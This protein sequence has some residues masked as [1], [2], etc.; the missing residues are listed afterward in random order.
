MTWLKSRNACWSPDMTSLWYMGLFG[1][2]T[3]A[4]ERKRKKTPKNKKKKQEKKTT[5]IYVRLKV[6]QG[7]GRIYQRFQKF[8]VKLQ[9]NLELI[10]K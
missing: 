1:F 3:E 4:R 8:P 9:V 6:N 2:I 10:V 7:H 5:C